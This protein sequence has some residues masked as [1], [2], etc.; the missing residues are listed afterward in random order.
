MKTINRT[1]FRGTRRVLV[2]EFIAAELTCYNDH[3][4]CL[5][6]TSANLS[7]LIDSFGRLV[8]TLAD[9]GLLTAPEVASLPRG[10]GS[11]DAKFGEGVGG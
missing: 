3:D 10:R 7:D 9:K 5:E 6:R 11:A 2:R 4:G 1:D 8:Q